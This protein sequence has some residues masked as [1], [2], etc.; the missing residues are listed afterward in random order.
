MILH[1]RNNSLLTILIGCLWLFGCSSP[2]SKSGAGGGETVAPSAMKLKIA[3]IPKSTGGEFWETVEKGARQAG[4]ELGV[5]VLWEGP[6]SETEIAEQN[7]IIESMANLGVDGLA[8]APLNPKANQRSVQA[9]VDAG[10]PTVVF[11]SALDGSAHFSYIATNNFQGGVLGFNSLKE[12]LGEMQGKRLVLFRYIQGTAST[13]ERSRGFAESVAASGA[14]LVADP[15]ADDGQITGCKKTSVNTLEALIENKKLQV[16]GIFC[17]N[18]TAS[19][20]TADALDDLR[21]SGVVVDVKF[22]GF[23]T[24]PRLIEELQAGNIDGLIAQDP[25]RMGSLAVESLV[26]HLRG[27]AVD[28]TVETPAVLVN[29]KNLA[30][31]PE[32]QRLV[33][34]TASGIGGAN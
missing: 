26:R 12:L 11:D 4:A 23:D 15:Y 32:I 29:K 2:T 17:A 16:D 20:A 10:I 24:S 13:E 27:E 31:D 21:K 14:T 1:L 22:V 3:V 19:L 30:E 33:G 28:A 6:V 18:L 34:G 8:V 9:A 5:E 25:L 7:K